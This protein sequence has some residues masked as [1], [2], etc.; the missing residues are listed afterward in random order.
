[1]L[2]HSN[3]KVVRLVANGAAKAWDSFS[4][5]A[6]GWRSYRNAG[7]TDAVLLLISA[8]DG[9]KSIRWADEV[10]RDASR[11]DRAID[12]NGYLGSKHYIDRAQT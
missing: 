10:V 11:A 9:R 4:V 6:N 12:A 3:G 8:G 1:M 2:N 5:P 7:E